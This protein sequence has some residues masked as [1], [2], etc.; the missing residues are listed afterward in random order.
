MEE[1][2]RK[3]L[4]WSRDHGVIHRA[5]EIL[6]WKSLAREAPQALVVCI[7]VWE[8][9]SLSSPFSS[10]SLDEKKKSYTC[11]VTDNRH[12]YGIMCVRKKRQRASEFATTPTA[13]EIH[14]HTHSN[15]HT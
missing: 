6:V 5:V 14:R 2:V 15:T 7:C 12:S 10:T 4:L 1:F 8:V 11:I 3:K 13:C 9:S